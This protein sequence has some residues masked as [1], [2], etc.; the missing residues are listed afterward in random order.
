M[1]TEL[2]N[3][4]SMRLHGLMYQHGKCRTLPQLKANLRLQARYT[5][6][7]KCLSNGLH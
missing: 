1:I 6:L 7:L 5:D 4:Y 2:I 3:R